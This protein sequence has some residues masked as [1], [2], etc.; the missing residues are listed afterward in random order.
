MVSMSISTLRNHV[1]TLEK[2][3]E[4]ID[5]ANHFFAIYD[6]LL[7]HESDFLHN[8]DC[9]LEAWKRGGELYTLQIKETQALFDDHDLRMNLALFAHPD[10]P[11]PASWLNLPI[12]CWRDHGGACIMMWNTPTGLELEYKT[13]NGS[14]NL[15]RLFYQPISINSNDG[16]STPTAIDKR[17]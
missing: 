9:L 14:A 7:K 4:P 3:L 13:M 15:I 12:F 5:Q 10:N 17:S 16:R 1:R 11:T 6:A 2:T 8:R